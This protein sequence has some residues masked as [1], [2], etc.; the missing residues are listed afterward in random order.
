MQEGSCYNAR[1]EKTM[2]FNLENISSLVNLISIWGTIFLLSLW[3]ALIF[4]TYRDTK[5][6]LKTP[7]MRFLGVLIVILLFIPGVLVYVIVRPPITIEESYLRTLEEEALLRAIEDS[8][9]IQDQ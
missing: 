7:L 2:D 8:E 5:A 4:W 6:R 9:I 1:L 3:L